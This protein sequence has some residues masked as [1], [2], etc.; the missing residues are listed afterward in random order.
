MADIRF[1][2]QYNMTGGFNISSG[3]PIDS[4]MY[5]ADIAH[6]L[7]DSNWSTVKPYP[8]LIVSAPDGQVRVFAP[9][10][11]QTYKDEKAWIKIGG[12]GASV[13]QFTVGADGK[14]VEA[15]EAG[16]VIYVTTGTE[17][18]PSGA[19]IVTGVG[20]VAKLGVTTATG[21]IAGDVEVLKGKVGDLEK[22]LS[23][24][25]EEY[26]EHI[27]EYVVVA[28]RSVNNESAISRLDDEMDAVENALKSVVKS[29]NGN[30][31]DSNGAVTL[32]YETTLAADVTNAPTT[33]AVHTAI[34]GIK[35]NYAISAS[36]EKTTEGYAKSYT[37]SQGTNEIVTIDIPKDL[38][39]QSGEVIVATE[40]D[41]AIDDKIVVGEEYIKLT[42]KDG[43]TPIYIAA[44]SLV[45]TYTSGTA[46]YITI[47]G[48]TISLNITNVISHTDDEL[49]KLVADRQGSLS[50]LVKKNKNAIATLNGAL[51][52]PGSVANRTFEGVE[53]L[54]DGSA[55]LNGSKS[56]LYQVAQNANSALQ[57]VKSG[58]EN[59]LTVT[60]DENDSTIITLTPVVAVLDDLENGTNPEKLLTAGVAKKYID[61]KWDWEII[62]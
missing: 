39:V 10:E 23:D 60:E 25:I 40:E 15:E 5:V 18:Y 30:T 22:D 19:Y 3:E 61:D 34:E 57:E 26:N 44:K 35:T 48:Y 56:S 53:R 54:I 8:G 13:A 33:G 47:D 7:L 37:I 52:T 50:T 31:P 36:T 1:L 32:T 28:Q 59:Q 12:G 62:A 24:H 58:N 49:G 14:I 41:K 6:I 4:R 27:A 29:V 20:T 17:A 51:N 42:I 11:G 2:N 16:Q 43:S 46:D 38:V 45:D 55:E 21:D 9:A